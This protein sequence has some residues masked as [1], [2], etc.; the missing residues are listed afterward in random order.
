M[1]FSTISY[2]TISGTGMCHKWLTQMINNTV[3]LIYNLLL[4]ITVILLLGNTKCNHSLKK[5][6][7]RPIGCPNTKIRMNIH[8][9]EKLWVSLQHKGYRT[10]HRLQKEEKYKT[11]DTW[12]ITIYSNQK[13][14][15][16]ANYILLLLKWHSNLVNTLQ[17]AFHK[18]F[19]FFFALG[20]S[21]KC[22][23]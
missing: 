14:L 13:Y 11:W 20:R 10:S 22:L 1:D 12:N 17:T 6:Y 9:C 19:F 16:M 5:S 3:I 8:I 2:G 4:L 23:K 7:W 21:K 18:G 15:F